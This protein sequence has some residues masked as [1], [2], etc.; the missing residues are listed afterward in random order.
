MPLP[1]VNKH[2]ELRYGT[3][4]ATDPDITASGL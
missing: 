3:F 2:R 1:S 4:S